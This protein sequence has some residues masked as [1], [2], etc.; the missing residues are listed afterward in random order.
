MNIKESLPII[1]YKYAWSS[2]GGRNLMSFSYL[3]FYYRFSVCDKC[4]LFI[5]R[6]SLSCIHYFYTIFFIIIFIYR[7]R[8]RSNHIVIRRTE[9]LK[10]EEEKINL[11]LIIL[12]E[13]TEGNVVGRS[14]LHH[15]IKIIII[16]FFHLNLF[17]IEVMEFVCVNL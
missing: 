2:F 8:S 12:E 1:T 5:Y 17:K 3:S 7:S 9:L 4:Y 11:T 15:L 14:R 16:F 13:K 10:R 6:Y